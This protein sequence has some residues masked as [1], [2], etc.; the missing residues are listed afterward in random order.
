MV[1]EDV[2]VVSAIFVDFS[3]E[4]VV[5]LEDCFVVDTGGR[6]V[7]EV[8]E[9]GSEVVEETDVTGN[10]PNTKDNNKGV[11]D[12]VMHGYFSAKNL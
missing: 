10:W 1:V 11:K 3:V 2:T 4:G 8:V 5:R 12:M 9:R 6:V 7:I